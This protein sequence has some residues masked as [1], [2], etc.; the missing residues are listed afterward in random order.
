MCKWISTS[1]TLS[2]SFIFSRQQLVFLNKGC[3]KQNCFLV[4]RFLF[5]LILVFANISSSFLWKC[6]DRH[7]FK[8]PP[9]ILL[10]GHALSSISSDQ[11]IFEWFKIVHFLVTGNCQWNWSSL[12]HCSCLLTKTPSWTP[13]HPLMMPTC[14]RLT[15]KKMTLSHASTTGS[16]A[17]LKPFMRN[18]KSSGTDPEWQKSTI[19]LT[20]CGKRLTIW[21]WLLATTTEQRQHG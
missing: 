10:Y 18:R 15:T 20:T 9:N 5:C 16:R 12:F 14:W 8:P 7:N 2:S 4:I 21:K 1:A 6:F 3:S 11:F 17:W 19:W 13:S